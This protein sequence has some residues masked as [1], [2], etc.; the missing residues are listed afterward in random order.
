MFEFADNHPFYFTV[1]IFLAYAAV[2][3]VVRIVVCRRSAK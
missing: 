3:D 2:V 1:I